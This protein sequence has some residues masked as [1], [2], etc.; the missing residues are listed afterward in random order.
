MIEDLSSGKGVV[1]GGRKQTPETVSQ[2]IGDLPRAIQRVLEDTQAAHYAVVA[3][4][5]RNIRP[6][7]I[8][9]TEPPTLR[10]SVSEWNPGTVRLEHLIPSPTTNAAWEAYR[11]QARAVMPEGYTRAAKTRAAQELTQ[12][13][14]AHARV[15]A[16]YDIPFNVGIDVYRHGVGGY[17]SSK[18][19]LGMIPPVIIAQVSLA[20]E[21]PSMP[22]FYNTGAALVLHEGPIEELSPVIESP[23]FSDFAFHLE[24]AVDMARHTILGIGDGTNPDNPPFIGDRNRERLFGG[25]H[26][27]PDADDPAVDWL[28]NQFHQSLGK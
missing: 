23:G 17:V 26:T 12:E 19:P 20:P 1:F 27:P 22:D 15:N 2:I 16:L 9:Q 24:E 6:G 8:P 28:R 21:H 5:A 10:V 14:R 25:L 4:A 13:E 11:R 7:F 18:L 3:H